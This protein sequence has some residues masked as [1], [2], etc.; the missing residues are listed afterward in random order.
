MFLGHEKS[1]RS[2]TRRRRDPIPRGG[3]RNFSGR[4][5][6]WDA[7]NATVKHVSPPVFR[8]EYRDYG[9]G[10]ACRDPH[11]LRGWRRRESLFPWVGGFSFRHNQTLA[12]FFLCEKP[13]QIFVPTSVFFFHRPSALKQARNFFKI[14]MS[15]VARVNTP[16][17]TPDIPA[18]I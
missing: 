8:E 1:Q 14:T 3:G 5:A 17:V 18:L 16:C 12:Y 4:A 13:D 7:P 10:L 11:E 2:N 9:Q 6:G 15:V